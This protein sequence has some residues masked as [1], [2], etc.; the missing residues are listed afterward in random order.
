MSQDQP[1]RPS[2]NTRAQARTEPIKYGDVFDVSGGLADQ[3]VAPR[4]AAM[5]QSAENLTLG[6]SPKGG[7]AAAM[8]SAARRNENAG[9]VGHDERSPAAREGMTVTEMDAPGRRVVTESVGGQVVDHFETPAPVTAQPAVT[10]AFTIGDALEAAAVTARDKPVTHSDASAIQAAEVRATGRTAVVPGGVG[11]A[12]KSA[13]NANEWTV[14][15]DDM[16]TLGDVLEDA[17]ARLP[18]DKAVTAVD[19]ERVTG[20]ELR[21]SPDLVTYPGGVADTMT[22]AARLNRQPT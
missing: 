5:M 15:E 9:L 14:D 11:A 13:A 1:R 20:A 4:D 21:N 22:A 6:Q 12:A 3:P 10:D 2:N 16:T 7:A 19:A 17:K 8:Q 18:A